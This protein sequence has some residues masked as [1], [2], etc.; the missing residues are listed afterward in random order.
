MAPV[1]STT[2]ATMMLGPQHR[3]GEMPQ[4]GGE[5]KEGQD[6]QTGDAAG[7]AGTGADGPDERGAGERPPGGEA[8]AQP[9]SQVRLAIPWLMSLTNALERMAQAIERLGPSGNER[10]ASSGN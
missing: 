2:T 1:M 8:P 6:H 10:L 5:G 4:D 7:Q 3:L 9:G